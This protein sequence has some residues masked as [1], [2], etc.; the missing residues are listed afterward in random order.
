MTAE[1]A[2][3]EKEWR[4]ALVRTNSTGRHGLPEK[5]IRGNKFMHK[6]NTVEQSNQQE[7]G[8]LAMD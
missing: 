7:N 4:T 8:Q 2:K 5:A 6:M 3:R 1:L